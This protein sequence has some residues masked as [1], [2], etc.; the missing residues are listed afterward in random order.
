MID[1]H[2]HVLPMVDD[3]ASSVEQALRMLVQAYEDGTDE[4]VLTPHLAYEYG[5][6]NPS[7]KIRDLYEDLKYIVDKERIP[8]VMHL[9]CEFLFSSL[10]TFEKHLDEITL[11]NETDYLLMEFFFDIDSEDILKAIDAVIEK[12]Y[13]P[14][15][16]HPERYECVKISLDV[17]HEGIEKGALFQMNK[18]SLFGDYGRTARETV[19]DLLDKHYIHFVGSDGHNTSS[20]NTYMYEAYR[21]IKDIYG[22]EYAKNIFINY[23]KNMLKNKDVRKN[24]LFRGEINDG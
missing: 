12:G 9:G 1:I 22:N 10:S 14:I 18:G 19:F 2:S 23:P 15:I 17:V 3:G 7:D 24:M 5:F 20:R 16:A 8:I 4:I 11:I 21:L 13:I 6:D